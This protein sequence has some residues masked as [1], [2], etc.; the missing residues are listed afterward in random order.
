[1]CTVKRCKIWSVK[2]AV[3]GKKWQFFLAF[4]RIVLTH[5]RSLRQIAEHCRLQ[6]SPTVDMLPCTRQRSINGIYIIIVPAK[7]PCECHLSPCV[8]AWTSQNSNSE[9]KWWT[10]THPWG[11]HT[12]KKKKE[13]DSLTVYMTEN[14]QQPKTCNAEKEKTATH[15]IAW[16][17]RTRGEKPRKLYKRSL[18][19]IEINSTTPQERKSWPKRNQ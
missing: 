6:Y 5:F 8:C 1:M 19:Y 16:Q 4:T 9:P 7:A 11:R 14:M 12:E 15:S 13:T 3:K 17:D 10:W 18:S 2:N